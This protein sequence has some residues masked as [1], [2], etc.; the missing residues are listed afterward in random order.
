LIP[1]F[2]AGIF[3]LDILKNIDIGSVIIQFAVL[4]FSLSIHEAA[5]AW[6]ADRCGDYSARY[7]GRVTLNPIP[8]I[9]LIG[10]ILFPLLAFFVNFPLIGW[11]KPVPINPLHLKNPHQD[12]MYISVAG[13]VS[14]LLAAVVAFLLLG[15]L[16]LASSYAGSVVDYIVATW[17]IPGQ[18]S[19]LAP[20]AGILFF[21][22]IINI[23]LAFFN[24]IPIPPL[25]GHWILAGLLPRNAA[26]A[27]QRFGSFGFILLY[28]LMWLGAFKIILIPINIARRMLLAF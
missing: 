8:H 21:M 23:A 12:Q 4:L 13:P 2:P 9:D 5:H 15:V 16:K 22:M 11:A 1:E 26:E 19:I 27:F 7:L 18:Q 6:M 24:L 25:D 3:K 17:T 14:N 28:A 10:T 20:I